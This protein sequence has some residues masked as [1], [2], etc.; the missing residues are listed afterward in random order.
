MRDGRRSQ[1]RTR[2]K[3]WVSVVSKRGFDH[4][5]LRKNECRIP[6]QSQRNIR[7]HESSFDQVNTALQAVLTELQALRTSPTSNTSSSET[8]SLARE[9][10]SHPHTSRLNPIND[11]HRQ[12]LK[13]SFP[14]FNGDDPTCWIYKAEQY[15]DFKNVGPDQQVQLASFHLEGITLQW[16]GWLTKFRGPLTWDEFT[17]AVQ[18][19]FGPTDH[20]D[21]S[22][23]LTRLK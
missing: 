4:G 13:L 22:E 17:T 16:H 12:H 3:P 9:E 8:N 21:P 7:R 11:H 15:F 14:K 5:Y 19:R 6:Q 18:L 2:Y 10:S 1:E 23:A 20:E